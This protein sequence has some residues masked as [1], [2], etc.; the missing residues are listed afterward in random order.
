MRPPCS[1]DLEPRS[2]PGAEE[3]R[4]P[5]PTRHSGAGRFTPHLGYLSRRDRRSARS[6]EAFFSRRATPEAESA[7]RRPRRESSPR[8]ERRP[9][10]RALR[11]MAP[12]RIRGSHAVLGSG[13]ARTMNN[14]RPEGNR[15]PD[16]GH[17][18]LTQTKYCPTNGVRHT[19]LLYTLELARAADNE[20]AAGSNGCQRAVISGRISARPEKTV[21][22]EATA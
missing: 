8:E 14:E 22:E 11:C 12:G 3:V 4:R 1:G 20:P 6:C 7:F 10:E 2:R 18:T 15:K 21:F 5:E 16:P 17:S 9:P 13:H 19:Y